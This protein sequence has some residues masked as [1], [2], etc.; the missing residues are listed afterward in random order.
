[1]VDKR[2]YILLKKRLLY[3]DSESLLLISTKKKKTLKM[4]KSESREQ[5]HM[6]QP[7]GER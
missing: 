6:T 1:M 3:D 7:K 4:I 2:T 5:A